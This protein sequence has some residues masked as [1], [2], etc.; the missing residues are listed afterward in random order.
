MVDKSNAFRMDPARA[1][2]RAGDQRARGARPPGHPGL[3]ELHDDRHRDAAQAA[4]RRRAGCAGW[5]RPATRRSRAPGVNGHRGAA[6]ADARV[7]ARARPSPRSFF[8]HQIAFNLIPAHRQVRRRR[9]HG[10]GDEAGQRDRARSSSCPTCRSRRPRC[11]CPSS[12]PTRWRSTPRPRSKITRERAREVFARLPRAQA[13]GRARRARY[14]MPVHG[15]GPGRLLRRPHPR[16]PLAARTRSTSGWW[17]TSSARAP[18]S[19]GVQIAE[20]LIR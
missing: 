10:R 11:A 19:N 13:L 20:L 2:G 15:R 17:A 3:P 4:A 12:P 5:S 9:L 16:G 6:R 7:G 8:Q 1:A 14:P 18:R